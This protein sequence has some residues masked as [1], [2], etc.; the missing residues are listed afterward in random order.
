MEEREKVKLFSRRLLDISKQFPDVCRVISDN[1]SATNVIMEGEVVAMDHFYEKMLPFQV[2][3]KRRRKYNVDDIMKE[4]PVCVFLFDIL[5]CDDESFLSKSFLIRRKKLEEIVLEKDELRLVK[6]KAIKLTE[7]LL[8]FFNEARKEGNEGI[9]AKSIEDNS[10]YQPGNRGF[11]WIKLKGLEGGKLKDSVDVV[12][13][14]A[15]YG[16]GRRTGVY[17]TYIGAVYDPV[18][19]KFIAFTRFFSGLTDE[20]S[21]SLT[22]D[23]EKYIVKKKLK[24]VIC[25][26]IP[27]V[28]FEPEV[29]VEIIGDEITISEKF[30]TLG[31]SMRFPVFQR[32]RP[33]KGPKSS[34][35][36]G[37]IDELYKSQ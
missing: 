13:V 1:I 31:Y 12:I 3:S 24:N 20:L 8:D 36:V 6:S 28:W 11:L 34:T 32:L 27:D 15:F 9:I 7:E 14:G 21:E 5:K 16:K 35:T 33:E 29:V 22:K 18:S 37:E 19:G 17:G 4:V 30:I 23:M 10:V 2:L 25:E 26:D